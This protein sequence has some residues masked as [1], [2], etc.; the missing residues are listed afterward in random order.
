MSNKP[1]TI[2]VQIPRP[3]AKSEDDGGGKFDPRSVWLPGAV[4][5]ALMLGTWAIAEF[6]NSTRATAESVAKIERMMIV[7]SQFAEWMHNTERKNGTTWQAAE[8]PPR[9]E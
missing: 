2:T 9:R 1:Q 6:V 5:V 8:L 3:G 4:V 7:P